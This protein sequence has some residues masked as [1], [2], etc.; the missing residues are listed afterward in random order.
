MK[1]DVVYTLLRPTEEFRHSL[2]SLKNLPHRNVWVVGTKPYWAKVNFIE[3]KPISS[4]KI[5]NTNHNWLKVARNSQISDPFIMMN[6]DF[7]INKPIESIEPE[8]LSSNL[9]FETYYKSLYPKS[10]YTQVIQNTSRRLYR[11]GITD[12]K[13]YEL[14]TPMIIYKKDIIKALSGYDYFRYPINIR[15]VAGNLGNYGGKQVRDV[16]VY[17]TIKEKY[18][19]LK[20]YQDSKFISTDDPAFL[21]E[22]G[23]Y[24]KFK[25]KE[26]SKY[27]IS[28]R[29]SL[30]L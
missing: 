27:D 21:D 30:S 19:S 24:I 16:K 10:K 26:V 11:L 13:S 23:N 4:E 25:F 5:A 12:A 7:F 18:R 20:N 8:Y 29:N 14:H 22:A 2:R 1:F 9:K 3:S 17:G 28:S 6:D 15:T